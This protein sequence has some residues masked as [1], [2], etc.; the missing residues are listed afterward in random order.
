MCSLKNYLNNKKYLNNLIRIQQKIL[1]TVVRIV[2]YL[3]YV[4][5]YFQNYS[6][7]II[8]LSFKIRSKVKKISVRIN[9][10]YDSKIM[11]QNEI[12]LHT[13]VI[14]RQENSGTYMSLNTI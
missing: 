12:Q 9:H 5:C 14:E 2:I 11:I 3:Q 13:K 8:L 1:I 10:I 7:Q 6:K 4:F